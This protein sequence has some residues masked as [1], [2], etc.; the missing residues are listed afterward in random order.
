ME[1]KKR[2]KVFF[3]SYRVWSKESPMKE[4]LAMEVNEPERDLEK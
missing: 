1:G 2:G 4:L 3:L